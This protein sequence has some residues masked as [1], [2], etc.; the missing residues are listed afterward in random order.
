MSVARLLLK[1]SLYHPLPSHLFALFE[2]YV[3]NQFETHDK[4]YLHKAKLLISAIIIVLPGFKIFSLLGYRT[5]LIPQ[6][7]LH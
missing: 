7:V 5:E 3:I 4:S 2:C 1:S 6:L